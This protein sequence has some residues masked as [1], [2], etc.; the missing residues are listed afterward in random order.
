MYFLNCS[1]VKFLLDAVGWEAAIGSDWNG[2]MEGSTMGASDETDDDDDDDDD[3]EHFGGRLSRPSFRRR[4]GGQARPE[5]CMPESWPPMWKKLG[6]LS[7]VMV[8]W[9]TM[10]IKTPA[11]QF[12]HIAFGSNI[13]I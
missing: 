9:Q 6:R 8:M 7:S 1:A 12:A 11:M 3:D 13:K 10:M 4:A 5:G 2:S